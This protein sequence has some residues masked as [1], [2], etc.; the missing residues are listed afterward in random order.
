V[1]YALFKFGIW[2]WQM[3]KF[4]FREHTLGMNLLKRRKGK[5]KS[6]FR[7]RNWLIVLQPNM[8]INDL[9]MNFFLSIQTRVKATN[10]HFCGNYGIGMALKD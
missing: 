4:L 5:T 9:V 6:G 7:F 8:L 10:R 1:K 2:I 3:A